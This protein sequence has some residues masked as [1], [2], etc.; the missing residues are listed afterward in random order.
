MRLL[1]FIFL[2]FIGLLFLSLRA[3]AN[4]DVRLWTL[5][6][7]DS[8][9]AELVSYDEPSGK[10][11]LKIKNTEDR[12]YDF[13]SLHVVDRAWLAQW[14]EFADGLDAQLKQLGG[15]FERIVT[16]GLYPTD[17][18]VYYPS[19][20]ATAPT[21]LPGLILF[22]PGGKAALYAKRH[23][24]AAEASGF[25]L[26]SCGTFRNTRSDAV[27][28]E[29]LNRFREVFPQILQR[30]R[31]DPTRL[32]LGGTSGGASRAYIFS[33]LISHP[34]AGIYANGGWLGGKP[35]EDFPFPGGMR[36]AMVNGHQDEAANNFVSSDSKI[37]IKAGNTIGVIAFEGAHQIP[38][39]SSQRQAFDWLLQKPDV[40]AASR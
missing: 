9:R 25:V 6:S 24:E 21:P 12:I 33:A 1:N 35:Y 32:F 20:S 27:E 19:S 11:T 14:L 13:N 31:L 22:H 34:W 7:G 17:L 10:V 23:V 29:L 36:V 28:D 39:P 40:P 30:V 16:T 26:V 37:L 4:N 2:I 5:A 38:P 15:R 18:F 3:H 8:F